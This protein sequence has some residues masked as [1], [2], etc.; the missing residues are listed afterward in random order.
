MDTVA[1]IQGYLLAHQ[2]EG[3]I[4]NSRLRGRRR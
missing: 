3:L 4:K 1:Q 2:Y